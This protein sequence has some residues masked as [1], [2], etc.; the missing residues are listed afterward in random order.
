MSTKDSVISFKL[1]KHDCTLQL[2]S[3][4]EIVKTLETC[5]C[6][7]DDIQ[8]ILKLPKLIFDIVKAEQEYQVELYFS[9]ILEPHI[10]YTYPNEY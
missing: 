7:M 3:S 1:N 4:I 10:D 5:H 2:L 9:K 6:D 8:P